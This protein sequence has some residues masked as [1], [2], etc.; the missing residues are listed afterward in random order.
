MNDLWIMVETFAITIV[1][2]LLGYAL[3]K[4]WIRCGKLK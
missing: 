3:G 2:V 4:G 1:S